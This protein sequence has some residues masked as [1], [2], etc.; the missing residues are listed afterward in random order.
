[1]Q[2]Y[3]NLKKQLADLSTECSGLP[4]SEALA[5]ARTLAIKKVERALTLIGAWE[6]VKNEPPG[7]FVVISQSTTDPTAISIYISD[8]TRQAMGVKK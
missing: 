1:M 8:Y 5:K 6:K 4:I 2:A 3:E 7:K